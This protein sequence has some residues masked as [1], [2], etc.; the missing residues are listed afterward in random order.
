MRVRRKR[1][2]A[3]QILTWESFIP[4][5]NPDPGFKDAL[6]ISVWAP[7]ECGVLWLDFS[8]ID[9]NT[10]YSVTIFALL[11]DGSVRPLSRSDVTFGKPEPGWPPAVIVNGAAVR[12]DGLLD[13]GFGV[14]PFERIL[15]I[16]QT[17][18]R[19]SSLRAA[20]LTGLV[21]AA[22]VQV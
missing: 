13:F 2:D 16:V 12:L 20:F 14:Y 3:S 4:P 11:D 9:F 21:Q 18:G 6:E 19:E 15:K 8:K 22:S 10:A 7:L 1:E 5:L 17:K